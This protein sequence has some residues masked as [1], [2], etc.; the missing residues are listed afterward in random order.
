MNFA[1]IEIS[2]SEWHRQNLPKPFS[3]G[4]AI[5]LDVSRR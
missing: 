1:A 5:P 3:G 4:G 2:V